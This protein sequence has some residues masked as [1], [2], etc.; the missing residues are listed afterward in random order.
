MSDT[1]RTDAC[2]VRFSTLFAGEDAMWVPSRKAR[3]LERE[4]SESNEYSRRINLKIADLCKE[5]DTLK[6][7]IED[8]SFW[9]WNPNQFEHQVVVPLEPV[10][11]VYVGNQKPE[12]LK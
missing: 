3:E 5:R 6:A 1:P 11:Y 10:E 8:L 12:G 7:W 9:A 2:E 4:L